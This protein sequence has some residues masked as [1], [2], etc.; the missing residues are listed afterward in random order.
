MS[1]QSLELTVGPEVDG[2]GARSHSV[3]VI[4]EHGVSRPGESCEDIPSRDN[5]DDDAVAH[6]REASAVVP[7]HQL[8]AQRNRIFMADPH[9]VAMH[10]I[11][12]ECPG[13][14]G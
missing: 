7:S 4:G 2:T 8:R 10:Y 1:M 9:D 3:G 6:D 11:C 13:N 12:D 5:P 14:R